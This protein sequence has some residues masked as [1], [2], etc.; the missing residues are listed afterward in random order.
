MSEVTDAPARPA[1]DESSS[2]EGGFIW[3]ELMTDD[4]EAAGK[5]YSAVVK[6]WTFGERVP[7]EVEYRMI[8]RSDGGNAGGVLTL[9]EEMKSGGARPAWLG[10]LHVRDVDAKAAA[11]KAEGGQAMMEP[12]DQAGVGRLAMVTDPQGAPFYLMDPTPPEHD[13]TAVSDVFSMDQPERV[14]WNELSTS[15]ADGAVDF[16]TRQFGWTQ[17]GSMDMGEFGQYRFVQNDGVG[18]GAIMPRMPEMPVSLWTFYIGVDDIDRAAKAITDNGGSILN[19]PMEI[20]GGEFALN[21]MDPQ[22]ASFGLV[23]PRKA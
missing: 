19:G 23:G 4:A 16:Y 9:N 22:G 3:Y 13:P 21:G 7:T 10:Y 18:I 11:I 17:E 12:W 14:R 6:G 1:N 15:D 20:P 2:G 8:Q 5:F